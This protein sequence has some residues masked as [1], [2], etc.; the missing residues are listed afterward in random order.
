MYKKEFFPTRIQ[1]YV[2]A[3]ENGKY[4]KDSMMHKLV[5]FLKSVDSGQQMIRTEHGEIRPM[6]LRRSQYLLLQLAMDQAHAGRPIR[7]RDLKS[8]KD[9]HSTFWEHLIGFLCENYPAQIGKTI[10]HRDES[11]KEIF[12]IARLA[13]ELKSHRPAKIGVTSIEWPDMRSKFTCTT[14]GGTSP[15]AGGT[16]MYVLLSERPKWEKNKD[17]SYADVVN[18][19]PFTPNTILIDEATACGREQFYTAW[20]KACEPDD[21]FDA[22][23][24]PWYISDRLSIPPPKGFCRTEAEK[25]LCDQARQEGIEISDGMLHWR[26]KKIDDIGIDAFHQDFPSTPEEAVQGSKGLIFPMLRS[27][28]I[29]ELPFDATRIDNTQKVGGMDPGYNDP[30]V[31]GSGFYRDRTLYLVSVWRQTETLAS[32]RVDALFPEHHYYVDPAELTERMEI[33]H[34]AD[35][36]GLRCRFSPAP[37]RKNPGEDCE[38]AELRKVL[39]MIDQGRLKILRS[40]SKQLILEGDNLAWDE[41]TGK[42]NMTRGEA[43][44]HF[45]TLKMLTYLV[46][47]VETLEVFNSLK[48]PLKRATRSTEW[49]G[50]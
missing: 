16:P 17:A 23:F 49:A 4:P 32:E 37:R 42:P 29:D 2:K 34:A 33:Q 11:T 10:A 15:G 38:S 44:G 12:D 7:I 26:R 1:K 27:C 19:V 21:V 18:S 28:V 31:I 46:M 50:Y 30:C 35:K 43:W 45:D 13:S 20:E 40:C 14:A 25:R 3:V 24:M 39:K 48:K 41:K 47:G 8:R 5:L 6:V 36:K 9:G 22:S